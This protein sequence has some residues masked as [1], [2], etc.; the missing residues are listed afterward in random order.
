MEVAG[1]GNVLIANPNGITCNGCSFV[2]TPA[3]TL[4]HGETYSG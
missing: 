1:K 3:I 2:N 4:N